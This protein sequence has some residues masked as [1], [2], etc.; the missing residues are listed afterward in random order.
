MTRTYKNRKPTPPRDNPVTQEEMMHLQRVVQKDSYIRDWWRITIAKCYDPSHHWFSK[1]GAHGITVCDDW[2][3][4]EER[5]FRNFVLDMGE[6]PDKKCT[7][8]L[9]PFTA[10]EFNKDTVRWMRTK[11]NLPLREALVTGDVGNRS[12]F[13]SRLYN[14]SN[15]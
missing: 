5:G 15:A 13:A 1:F 7:L 3:W 11:N 8:E 2:R 4:N 9:H 6:R 12:E 10:Q 14:D